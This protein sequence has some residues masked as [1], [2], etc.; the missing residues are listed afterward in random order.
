MSSLKWLSP[1]GCP[2]SWGRGGWV[3]GSLS[4]SCSHERLIAGTRAE[5]VAL[6]SLVLVAIKKGKKWPE[7]KAAKENLLT[8]SSLPRYHFT[9]QSSHIIIISRSSCA[10]CRS[11]LFYLHFPPPMI[12]TPMTPNSIVLERDFFMSTQLCVNRIDNRIVTIEWS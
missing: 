4:S 5:S 1:Q 3:V 10:S 8:F 12:M 2:V 6:D 7:Q 9:L 11:A